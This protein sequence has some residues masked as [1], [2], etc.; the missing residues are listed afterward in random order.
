MVARCCCYF[1]RTMRRLDAT[2]AKS[3][4]TERRVEV[5]FASTA[6][7]PGCA[8]QAFS[9]VGHPAGETRPDRFAT[10]PAAQLGVSILTFVPLSSPSIANLPRFSERR[11]LCYARNGKVPI[12]FSFAQRAEALPALHTHTSS[13]VQSRRKDAPNRN[14]GCAATNRK[15]SRLQASKT[16]AARSSCSDVNS[17]KVEGSQD[18]RIRFLNAK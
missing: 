4:D 12:R 8:A 9:Q 2:P 5:L 13:Y 16:R 15:I 17:R 7:I 14:Y 6:A 3:G 10:G 18:P 11:L 1:C